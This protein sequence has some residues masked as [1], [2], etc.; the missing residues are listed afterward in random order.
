MQWSKDSKEVFFDT[1]AVPEPAFYRVRISDSHLQSIV[2]IS[3]IRAYY[4]LFGPWTGLA[5]DGSPLLVRNVSNEEVYSL[6]LQL[7]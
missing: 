7:P 3:G 5:P 2:S 4:G 6:D 1:L